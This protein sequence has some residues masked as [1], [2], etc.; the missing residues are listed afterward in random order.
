MA[1]SRAGLADEERL[2]WLQLY[3]SDHVGPQT[4]LALMRACGSAATA[5]EAI[6]DFARRGGG[7]RRVRLCP[8]G[9]AERELAGLA[10]MGARLL[11]LRDPEFPPLLME[12]D[13]APP[14]LSVLGSP[15]ALTRRA[16]AIVGGRNASAAGRT[17]AGRLA[18]A[19]GAYDY[20]VVSGLA[21][22]IDAAAHEGSLATGT[23]AVIAGGLDRIYPPEHED[24][25]RR[26]AEGPGAVVTEMPLGWTARARDF[27]RRNRVIAGIGAGTVLVEAALRSGSLITARL[28]TELGREVMAAPGSPLDPRC[29]GSNRL[30][31]EGATLIT[32]ADHVLEALTPL[33]LPLFTH[34]AM[35][36]QG[37][38]GPPA[39]PSDVPQDLRRDVTALLGPS[40]V[41]VDEIVRQTRAPAHLIQTVLLELEL[42]GRLERQSGGRVA[43]TGA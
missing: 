28:A 19:L 41:A 8:R 38:A 25:V 17:F 39:A 27:P 34:R 31:R 2:D 35:E 6:P 14:L 37:A 15:E 5:L 22:G 26:I 4:F 1:R 42:A 24:L 16:V 11:T 32:S 33:G 40:P 10:R 36:D 9:D 12:A 43:L 21:R 23:V 3:R 30:I 20:V 18:T 29:E 13:G 7:D